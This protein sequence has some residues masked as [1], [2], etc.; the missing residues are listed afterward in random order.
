MGLSWRIG[1]K[2]NIEFGKVKL[3]KQVLKVNTSIKNILFKY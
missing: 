1:W 3:L 2:W